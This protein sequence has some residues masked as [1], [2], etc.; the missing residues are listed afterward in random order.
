MK[1]RDIRTDKIKEK[2]EE[3]STSEQYESTFK[4]TVDK[5][6]NSTKK[7]SI[8][9]EKVFGFFTK[10][11]SENGFDGFG[12]EENTKVY[13]KK[14][15]FSSTRNSDIEIDVSVEV[16]DAKNRL[17]RLLLIECK[18]Y[19]SSVKD[20]DVL[21]FFGQI[22]GISSHLKNTVKG[23]IFYASPD[24][25]GIMITKLS[26]QSGAIETA[27]NKSIALGTFSLSSNDYRPIL[28]RTTFESLSIISEEAERMINEE[29]YRSQIFDYA[30][31][32]NGI[33][34]NA[35]NNFLNELFDRRASQITSSDGNNGYIVDYIEDSTIE[36]ISQNVLMD[37][38]YQDGETPLSQIA[39]KNN[40]IL[41]YESFDQEKS[42][43]LGKIS[44]EPTVI[45]IFR[46]NNESNNPRERFT[47]AHELGH[48]FLGHSK[49]IL[50]EYCRESDVDLDLEVGIKDIV[51]MEYQ[52]NLFASYLLLPKKQLLN[53]F[54]RLFNFL[55]IRA[56]GS[57]RYLFVDSQQENYS[58]YN[59][60][61]EALQTKYSVSKQVITIRLEKLG[62]II[63][64]HKFKL[65][66]QSSWKK[67]PDIAK[68]EVRGP[69]T[70]LSG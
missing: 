25:K 14:K 1:I 70:L 11:I 59:S 57:N 3:S 15:Y 37:S 68:K 5:K 7:G 9:E 10:L 51:R 60:M 12:P 39:E 6:F 27:K 42:E 30:F 58:K 43:I 2:H 13:W 28:R 33:Y 29:F 31:Y 18:N 8:L 38:K 35:V 45:T 24:V 32:V 19:E 49:Y 53:E 67:F 63:F 61:I 22:E 52:A 50:E 41:N 54:L 36:S 26:F 21:S 34:T 65:N 20:K 44:F 69:Y 56:R 66:M 46:N 48:F 62:L 40:I 4:L 23:D 47:L 17:C 16:F 64:D 55:K